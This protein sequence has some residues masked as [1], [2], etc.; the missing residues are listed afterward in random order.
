MQKRSFELFQLDLDLL[1]VLNAV[2]AEGSSSAAPQFH[3][4]I[5]FE[6]SLMLRRIRKRNT[7]FFDQLTRLL[8][9]PY[10][11]S[12]VRMDFLYDAIF[13]NMNAVHDEEL[14]PVC[15][16]D[17][18]RMADY[19]T[20]KAQLYH[21]GLTITG[22][23]VRDSHTG[24]RPLC[25]EEGCATED[26][27]YL[28]FV[29]SASMAR[30]GLVLFVSTQV[31]APLMERLSLGFYGFDA[32]CRRLTMPTSAAPTEDGVF[33]QKDFRVPASK[34]Q[35]Y[36]GLMLSDGSS[37][38][39]MGRRW[40][41][42]HGTEPDLP[43][44]NE[45]TV[46]VAA[47][48][49][50]DAAPYY[51]GLG[52]YAWV[53]EADSPDPQA[54]FAA[55]SAEGEAQAI[56]RWEEAVQAWLAAASPEELTFHGP[57]P[58]ARDLGQHGFLWAAALLCRR[59]GQQGRD[60]SLP[61]PEALSR[62]FA[63]L[64]A[65]PDGAARN[66]LRNLLDKPQN[67]TI[68]LGGQGS[69]TVPF[70]GTTLS[71]A[72]T[73]ADAR[74]FTAR[75]R[76]SAALEQS[77]TMFDGMGLCDNA[78]FDK[79]ERL[80]LGEDTGS[81]H[82]ISAIILR[83]PWLKGTLVRCDFM[84]FF[85]Q[86]MGEDLAGKKVTD[87]FGVERDLAGIS[88]IVTD[89]MLKGFKYLKNLHTTVHGRKARL[90]DPW[91]YYWRQMEKYGISMLITGKNSPEHTTEHTNFQFL[92][93]AGVSDAAM[94]RLCR[95]TAKE[96]LEDLNDL[97]MEQE[98][99]RTEEEEEE[100]IHGPTP[101]EALLAAAD[102]V[103]RGRLRSTGYVHNAAQAY[104]RSRIL[105]AM[106]GRLPVAGDFRYL[107]PD[108]MAMLHYL[109]DRY[110][111]GLA[112]PTLGGR[113]NRTDR[114]LSGHG[115]F[116]A[117]SRSTLFEGEIAALRNPHYALGESVLLSPLEEGDR[118]EYD[119]WFGH[120]TSVLMVPAAAAGT[121][122][123]AD[124]DG[125][126]ALLLA[127]PDLVADLRA[128]IERN[129]ETLG[130]MMTHRQDYVPLLEA[131]MAEPAL[132]GAAEGLLRW[133]GD[134]AF[135]PQKDE[136]PFF[137][138]NCCPPL[139]FGCETDDPSIQ[140]GC[141]DRDLEEKLYHA[142]V[143][144]TRQ[145]IGILS[146]LALSYADMAYPVGA[147]AEEPGSPWSGEA[148]GHLRSW[149]WHWRMVSLALENGA[150]IDMAKTGIC[151]MAAPLRE[152]RPL[153]RRKVQ[154]QHRQLC[155][156]FDLQP[157]LLD[158]FRKLETRPVQGQPIGQLHGSDFADALWEG[159]SGSADGEDLL[160][161]GEIAQKGPHNNVGL[162]PYRIYLA[163]AEEGKSLPSDGAAAHRR[164]TFPDQKGEI[165]LRQLCLRSLHIEEVRRGA[166]ETAP[167]GAPEEDRP[168]PLTLHDLVWAA[169]DRDELL[170]RYLHHY[171]PLEAPMPVVTAPELVGDEQ[172]IYFLKEGAK[173]LHLTRQ[174]EIAN[175]DALCL[176]PEHLAEELH[177]LWPEDSRS[178]LAYL[179]T[180]R[181]MLYDGA[182]GRMRPIMD[183]HL[184]LALA[185]ADI[186]HIGREPQGEAQTITLDPALCREADA[187]LLRYARGRLQRTNHTIAAR[188]LAERCRY[189]MRN[190]QRRFALTDA[191]HILA[192][193]STDYDHTP[194][195]ALGI[196]SRQ[197][198]RVYGD[199]EEGK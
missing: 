150:E 135:I 172:G 162:L 54:F 44:L 64:R 112:H 103:T 95:R 26:I 155:D 184:F 191:L 20:L 52:D 77:F 139:I 46:F 60:R 41:A 104:A 163:L 141:M 16:P 17:G 121:M 174:I 28:P 137:R 119:R 102:D 53:I 10:D 88:M 118:R 169:G 82:P 186:A 78:T 89:S 63:E 120:L 154:P 185:G 136:I 12:D 132:R 199:L 183:D 170:S 161:R 113:L 84:A 146:N 129:K 175:D 178:R 171:L 91:A 66:T 138:K 11:L 36:L 134:P 93:T 25:K 99:E 96:I 59:D 188:R 56:D 147:P 107:A 70:G 74:V 108:L 62:L 143:L 73:P 23:P 90:A 94:D 35:A 164:L 192:N 83:L 8:G 198:H 197:L 145:R 75:L 45:E 115:C 49:K 4:S 130:Y 101:F 190:L 187:L 128:H 196:P 195:G 189:V 140:F 157:S 111:R 68:T 148:Y 122:G 3:F 13:V 72:L 117:P 131:C 194:L 21:G 106:K 24:C 133:V 151:P 160:R 85:R 167:A 48:L 100:N 40:R 6:Q 27:R 31:F 116:Y 80:L 92:S 181:R 2:R 14:L 51:H 33:F 22:V 15:A 109:C 9:Q 149:L 39:E 79:L 19:G 159:L 105:D 144:T 81:R 114:T 127:E 142:F 124:F 168:N 193:Y 55:F 18:L 76:E 34:F 177:R 156:L 69:C 176:T 65:E 29:S 61:L 98:R 50:V 158:A 32:A 1:P 7:I 43:R 58:A 179:C 38:E 57:L 180:H 125:D 87:A 71:L 126:R 42:D 97:R 30:K 182:R 123:G 152:N 67:L 5:T 165:G 173:F 37:L 47:D 86:Q 166:E 110:V 153:S